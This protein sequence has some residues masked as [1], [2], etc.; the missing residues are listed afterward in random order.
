MNPNQHQQIQKLQSPPL[1]PLFDD[2][3]LYNQKIEVLKNYLP[4]LERWHKEASGFCY[5]N[6]ICN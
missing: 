4:S 6:N 2:D 1:S 3:N 5:L